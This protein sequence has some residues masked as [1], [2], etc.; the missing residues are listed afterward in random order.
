M[1]VLP[2][3]PPPQ[4]YS[5]CIA[6]LLCSK[7]SYLGQCKNETVYI[8]LQGPMW[9]VLW[10]PYPVPVATSLILSASLTALFSPSS[11]TVFTAISLA[12]PQPQRHLRVLAFVAPSTLVKPSPSQLSDL[13]PHFPCDSSADLPE[14]FAV[15]PRYNGNT[16]LHPLLTLP[17][18]LP[19]FLFFHSPS[20]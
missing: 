14:A 10:D 7:S 19:H 15:H 18:S 9:S 3:L 1:G 4:I 2:L 17:S 8:G 11:H 16:P 13:S 12:S 20:L 6:S 5:Q